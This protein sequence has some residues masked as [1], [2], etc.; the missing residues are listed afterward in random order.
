VTISTDNL[1]FFKV[2]ER[3]VFDTIAILNTGQTVGYSHRGGG[4][5]PIAIRL[6]RPR[7]ERLV[8]D[9]FLTTPIPANVLPGDRRSSNS[10]TWSTSPKNARHFRCSATMA[11]QRRWSWPSW[12]DLRSAALRHARR[13]GSARRDG[14]DR[15]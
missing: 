10:A 5:T 6:E 12:R 1:E 9:A 4:R 13:P 15:A 8:D 11:A 7:S 3:D 14:L 2:E